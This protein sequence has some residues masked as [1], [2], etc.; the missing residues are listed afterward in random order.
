MCALTKVSSIGTALLT[1]LLVLWPLGAA[2]AESRPPLRVVLDDNYPPYA[3]RSDDGLLQ[4][5]LP[6]LWA[7][8]EQRSGQPVELIATDWGRAKAIMHQGSAEVIDTIF[9]TA[10]RDKIYDFSPPYARLEVAIFFDESISG[11]A[12]PQSLSGFTVGVKDGDACID[13]LTERKVNDLRRYPNYQAMIEAASKQ[14]LRVFCMD[15]PPAQYLLGRHGIIE[16]FRRS[17]TL[18]TGELHRAVKKG[19]LATLAK[20]NG[21]FAAIS[22]PERQ[23][24]EDKWLGTELPHP[25]LI[26]LHRYWLVLFVTVITALTLLSLA[27]FALRRQV[28]NRTRDLTETLAMLGQTEVRYRSIFEGA[29]D[30]ILILDGETVVDCNRCAESIFGL[31]R[32]SIIGHNPAMLSPHLQADGTESQ[33]RIFEMVVR[34]MAG[35]TLHFEWRYGNGHVGRQFD[36]EVTLSRLDTG[37]KSLLQAV[38]RDI[39]QQKAAQAEIERLAWFDPLTHLP[40]RRLLMERLHQALSRCQ[41]HGGHGALLLIDLDD[42]RTLNDTRGHAQGDLLLVELARRLIKALRAEDFIARLGGDEFVVVL[43]NLGEAAEAALNAENV[44]TKALSALGQP[45]TLGGEAWHGTAS[46]GVCLFHGDTAETPDE[47][48]KRAE[49]AMYR[50]KSAGRNNLRFFDPAQQGALE[51]RVALIYDL[52]QALPSEQL[53]LH[54]QVQVD[55]AGI[56]CGAEG[57]LRWRHPERGLVS[58]AQFI[59]LAEET[60]LIEPIG[61]WVIE[62][63]CRL[64]QDWQNRPA[65]ADLTLSI[66]VSARQ[67]RQRNFVSDVRAAVQAA[68]IDPRRLMLELTE[69]LVV[70]DVAGTIEKMHALKSLGLGFSLDDFGT[71]YSSLSYLKRLPLDELKIDQSFVRD[72]ES[73]ESDAVIIRT[74]IAMAHSLGLAVIAEGVETASQRQWL[75]DNGCTAF[76]G[77]LFGRP[78]P[79]T[80]FVARYA[81]SEP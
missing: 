41:R 46:A 66:N 15:L 71:G 21:G 10:E 69:S 13:Y 23:A 2:A 61:Q 8:W 34:A 58:P 77:W 65:L 45:L 11:I 57:L 9:R 79:V 25:W 16:R 30:A 63:A 3:F 74:I 70:D 20:V 4:G 22:A 18:Y 53:E 56:P 36:A 55:A 14:R 78:L 1:F 32:Q 64:L 39:S 47:T 29:N 73:D 76:Q 62:Q 17:P 59:P 48:L 6:E 72:I 43:E 75:H 24:I 80:E 60:G 33:Q 7:L 5:I 50:A 26:F 40:N 49:A 81:P 54:L 28:A 12:G 68:G 38:L 44:A 37:G 52:R 19:D 42:F 27:T 51:A 35:E 67:F 31:P